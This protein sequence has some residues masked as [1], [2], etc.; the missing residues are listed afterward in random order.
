MK[1]RLPEGPPS[2]QASG[3]HSRLPWLLAAGCVLVIFI[4]LLS[5][6][7]DR[8]ATAPSV[9][10]DN[11]PP[12]ATGGAAPSAR[13]WFP[14]R[15]SSPRSTVEP[16]PTA[17]EIVSNKVAQFAQSRRKLAHAMAEHFKLAVPDEVERFFDAA[18]AGR[19]DE[20]KAIYQSLRQQRENGGDKSW[21]GPHWRTIIETQGTADAAH[22]WPAQKL[23]DYG[24][25][26]LGSLRPG[27]VYVG[28]TDPGCFIPTLLNETSDGDRHIVLT[29]NALADGTYL[30]YLGFLY[31][32]RMTTLTKDDSQRMFQ[33]YLADAQKRFGHDQQ[34]PNEPRQIRPGEDVRVIEN[35]VQVSGQVPVMAINENLLQ[36]LMKN[37]PGVSFALEE[38]FPFRSTYANAAPLGPIMELGVQDPQNALTADR[39]AQSVAYWQA[40]EQQLLADPDASGSPETLRAYSK[41]ATSQAHLFADR[42]FNREAEQ[43]YRVATEI[44]PSSTEAVFGYVSLLIGQARFEDAIPIAENAVKASAETREKRQFRDLLEQ[45][46]RKAKR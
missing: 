36:T 8:N 15:R 26:V 23:L 20:M 19:Y 12:A 30:D 39:A 13:D 14:A 42:S 27:M 25:A 35:K 31:G 40:T 28:G 43:A 29:Q 7:K 4:A 24:N 38:S 2:R 11:P 32:E 45:L 17:T 41:M 21:Y 6:R 46:Q 33:E 16:A 3:P 5:L 1:D 9:S 18:E 44:C 22:D 37:T 10:A 34:F